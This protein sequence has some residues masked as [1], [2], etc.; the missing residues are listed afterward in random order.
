MAEVEG[1]RRELAKALEEARERLDGVQ[2]ATSHLDSAETLIRELNGRLDGPVSWELKREIVETLVEGILVETV[3]KDGRKEAVVH[4]TYRFD[5]VES[6]I[7]T[8]TDTRAVH[9]QGSR[10]GRSYRYQPRPPPGVARIAPQCDGVTESYEGYLRKP[11][12][13]SL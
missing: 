11:R 1:E 7:E 8:R 12:R 3:E 10:I 4:V 13:H 9:N 2:Q 5:P 6:R